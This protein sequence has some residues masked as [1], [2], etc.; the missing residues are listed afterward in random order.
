MAVAMADDRADF[1]HYGSKFQEGL[2]QLILDDRVF[3]DQIS[4][5]LDYQYLE[6]RYL[7]DF[8][9]KIFE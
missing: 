7:K 8:V 2:A 5:V 6:V 9:S 1:S 4:E 3:D